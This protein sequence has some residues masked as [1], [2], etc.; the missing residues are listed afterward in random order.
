LFAEISISQSQSYSLFATEEPYTPATGWLSGWQYRK[1]HNI[2]GAIGAGSN[3]QIKI[4]TYYDSAFSASNAANPSISN[5]GYL[6]E[7]IVYDSV[8]ARYWWIFEDRSSSPTVIRMA[9]ATSLDGSWTV[10]PNPVIS[11]GTSPFIA[12]F[13]DYWYIYYCYNGD[14]WVQKSSSV[15]TGYSTT[16]INNPILSKGSGS[17]WDNRRA[18]EPYVILEGGTYYLFYMGENLSSLYEE[19]GYATSSSPTAGFAKYSGNP[20]LP[21]GDHGWDSGQDKAADPFVFK[22][23]N[24]FYVGVTATASDKT[25][26]R[27]G[28]YETTDFINFIHYADNPV[29][30]PG[31]SGSWDAS[32]VLRGAVS[33][34]DGTLYFPYAG[35]D[36]ISFRCGMTIFKITN[37]DSGEKVYLNGHCRPDF[38]DI[39]FTRDDGVT[40]LDYW[41]ES[42]TDSSSAIF[43][44]EIADD[45]SGANSAIYV[46]YGKSD[47]TTTSNG[48]NTF[49][50][51][52]DF[53]GTLDKWITVSGTWAV[54]GETLTIE[55]PTGQNYWNNYLVTANPVATNATAIRARV[56]AEQ[57]GDVAAHPG[58]CWHANSLTG[59]NH[60]NDH[61]YFRPHTYGASGGWPNIQP[62]YYD[63]NLNWY[64]GEFGSYFSWNTWNTIEVRIPSSG[65]VKLYGG[66][67]FWHDWGNQQYS[68]DHIG[69][70]AHDMGKDYWDYVF[71]RKYVDPEP[72]HGDWGTEELAPTSINHWQMT[73]DFRDL[74]N[75][76]VNSKVA[77]ELYNGSQLLNYAEG[78][79]TLLD[80]KYTLKTKIDSYLIDSRILNTAKYGN[81]TV[82]ISLQMKQHLSTPGGYIVSNATIL[83]IAIHSETTTNLTFTLSGLPGRLLVKVPHNAEYI[84]KDESYLQT[85]TWD[86]PYKLILFDSTNS[87]CEFNFLNVPP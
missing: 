41:L 15:N 27:I 81:S 47:A 11:R 53:S 40:L 67:L 64:D 59:I 84:K 13:G 46:Y 45:L 12:K 57:A 33:S 69:C 18:D 44:V 52:D 73:F 66:D 78:E 54:S 1:M 9:Y 65:N 61:V 4:E 19:T 77:W 42:E 76:I 3:Y 16:G 29:L 8:T 82:T 30:S 26:W 50:F 85:W 5:N 43:W 24:V 36:G 71:V 87:T 83:S 60:R 58:L 14:I 70:V 10:E 62:A 28:F 37:T 22:Y 23:G 74:D 39:R 20:V 86:Y 68:Y 63:G 49:L 35:F 38:G 51:F 72:L 21:T 55:P 79:Y 32:A 25:N 56:K 17:T 75:A 2:I 7:D 34:F 31:V 80:G 48:T 6:A